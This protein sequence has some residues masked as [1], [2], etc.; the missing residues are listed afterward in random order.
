MRK[1]L[2]RL[3][4]WYS[5]L[6]NVKEISSMQGKHTIRGFNINHCF[7]YLSVNF[8]F[9]DKEHTQQRNSGWLFMLQHYKI[10][11]GGG[12]NRNLGTPCQ[13]IAGV[14]WYDPCNP[15]PQRTK[16]QP[17]HQHLDHQTGGVLGFCKDRPAKILLHF[18]SEAC[19]KNHA[20]PLNHKLE[21]W[22]RHTSFM[23]KKRE[24]ERY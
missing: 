14:S 10:H 9:S 22:F 12:R 23:Y 16:S 17:W 5:I 15:G 13:D 3:Q 7:P 21:K 1:Y 11:R 2:Q 19:N 8:I 24:G 4:K 18:D 6:S 20:H